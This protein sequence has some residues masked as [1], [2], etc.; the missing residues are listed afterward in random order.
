MLVIPENFYKRQ[1]IKI[2]PESRDK[3]QEQ[4]QEI[5]IEKIDLLVV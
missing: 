1:R 5:N 4:Y 3:F 2:Y